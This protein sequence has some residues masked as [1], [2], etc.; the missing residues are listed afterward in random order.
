LAADAFPNNYAEWLG[1][2]GELWVLGV[3]IWGLVFLP[4]MLP[5]HVAPD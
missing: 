4:K 2:S 5:H 3:A 1:A